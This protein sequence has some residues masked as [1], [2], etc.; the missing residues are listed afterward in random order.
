MKPEFHF[1]DI[2]RYLIRLNALCVQI[3]IWTGVFSWGGRLQE[4]LPIF[5]NPLKFELLLLLECHA[6]LIHLLEVL[7]LNRLILYSIEHP[8]KFMLIFQLFLQF[9]L[10]LRLILNVDELQ[11][12]IQLAPNPYKLLLFCLVLGSLILFNFP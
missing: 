3:I 2:N 7:L 9:G 11:Q 10:D 8:L 1:L 5:D 4:V 12:I 6:I